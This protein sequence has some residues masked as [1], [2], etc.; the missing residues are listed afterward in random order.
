MARENFERE[1]QR[2][3]DEV[4]LL[5]SMAEQAVL[6]A[7]TAL[8]QM[9]RKAAR[10][11]RKSDQNI[12]EKRYQIEQSTLIAIAT[13]Q[14]MARDLRF[15]AAILEIITEL[16]RIGDYA[17]G[18]AGIVLMLDKDNVDVPK[19]DLKRMADLGLDMLHRALGAFMA[20]DPDTARAITSEDDEIDALYNKIYRKLLKHMMVDPSTVDNATRLMWAAHNLERLGDRVTNICERVVFVVTGEIKELDHTED[21]YDTPKHKGD[22]AVAKDAPST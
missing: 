4:L 2:L 6:D 3:Q 8:R 22:T 12:N 10:E 17:K 14:P 19:G 13:Q 9:D 20:R 5:G 11:I 18:I 7:V 16:E 21:E 15:L 1:L